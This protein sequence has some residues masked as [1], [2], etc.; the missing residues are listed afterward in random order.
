MLLNLSR[1]NSNLVDVTGRTP[2]SWVAGNGHKECITKLLLESEKVKVNTGDNH[3]QTHLS[4]ASKFGILEAMR[5]LL[6]HGQVDVNFVDLDTQLPLAWAAYRSLN[7]GAE[8][9][10]MHSEVQ[11]D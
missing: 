2:L 6:E 8:L 7:K 1:I 9:L 11:P 10:L 3:S 4:W 5:L